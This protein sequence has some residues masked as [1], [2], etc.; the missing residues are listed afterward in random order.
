MTRLTRLLI[1]AV[2]AVLLAPTSGGP[3]Q[4]EPLRTLKPVMACGVHRPASVK[5]DGLLAGVHV[6]YYLDYWGNVLDGPC[7]FRYPDIWSW[8]PSVRSVTVTFRW[9]AGAKLLRKKT[10]VAN[11]AKSATT[12]DRLR[13]SITAGIGDGA[14][15]HRGRPVWLR[16]TLK[17]AGYKTERAVIRT[18][19]E[20]NIL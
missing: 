10:V 17:K 14:W 4:A 12:N 3:V 13:A 2:C 6:G 8:H 11:N 18:F 15:L 20:Y 16:I 5:H 1:V 7:D 19:P 9:Y